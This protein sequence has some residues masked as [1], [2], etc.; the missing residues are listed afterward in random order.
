VPPHDVSGTSTQP[1]HF[2]DR[3]AKTLRY[4]NTWGVQQSEAEEVY[5]N[6]ESIPE[7]KTIILFHRSPAFVT[8]ELRIGPRTV[9]LINWCD[10]RYTTEELLGHL[11]KMCEIDERKE[12]VGLQEEVIMALEKLYEK[13][14]L[15]FAD[16]SPF[17]G[18]S[19]GSR[20]TDLNE[21]NGLA[22]C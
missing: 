7:T 17:W 18:W 21:L 16:W 9:L 14:I 11:R 19:N 1:W 22:G 12:P 4:E 5:A 3:D 13:K 20:S 2:I 10:G 6:F 15:V 8:S